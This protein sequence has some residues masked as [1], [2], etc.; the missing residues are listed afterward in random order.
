MAPRNAVLRGGDAFR[1][2]HLCLRWSSLRGHEKLCC[3]RETHVDT[4]T[5]AIGGAPHGATK[6][7]AAWGRRMRTPPL[8][9]SV[10]LLMAPQNAVQFG[11]DACGHRHWGLQWLSLIHISE[12]TRPEPI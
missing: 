10:E 12:P 2:R 1:H 3:V 7:R 8:G 6:R 11:G 5:G 4:A 9:P